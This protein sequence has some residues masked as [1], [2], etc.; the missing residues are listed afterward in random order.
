MII[1]GMRGITT[2]PDKGEFFCPGCGKVDFKLKRV[3]R[4]FTL[5]FIP[6]IPLNKLGEYVECQ[7]C[8]DTYNE[9]ILDWNPED[10]QKIDEIAVLF[11][12][13]IK[14]DV[15]RGDIAAELEAAKSDNRTVK[16]YVQSL[17]GGLNE[18][19]KRNWRGSGNVKG[20]CHRCHRSTNRMT[21][22]PI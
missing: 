11:G 10:D 9:R 20:A 17:I 3:R 16:E 19:G 13:I 5:Y 8:K 7:K 2:T 15:D 6:V 14:E 22:K 1:F 4:F 21:F 12:N 18:G